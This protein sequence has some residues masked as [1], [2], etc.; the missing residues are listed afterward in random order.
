MV[1]VL[2]YVAL[3]VSPSIPRQTGKIKV[4][5]WTLDYVVE[6]RGAPCL[7][8]GS[9]IYYPRTFSKNL[10]RHLKLIF[11]DLPW[12]APA[13]GPIDLTKYTIDTVADEV[14][15]IRQKLKLDKPI[16]MGHSV[17]GSIALEYARRHPDHV[18]KLVMICSPVLMTSDRYEA[19]AVEIWKGASAERRRLQEENWRRLPDFTKHPELQADV[20]N[21]VAMGP[22][23]WRDPH[24]N[25]RWIWAGMTI[26]PEVLHHLFDDIFKNYDMFG[27][28]RTV[29]VPSFVATGRF[30]YVIP[31]TSWIQNR[32][33][34][35]LTVSLF[36]QS[37][38][39]PQL[40]E[41]M[42]FDKRLLDWWSLL[43]KT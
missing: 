7:V 9:S 35:N 28:S 34:P 22:K 29:P 32:D 19:S 43:L 42:L 20:E 18:A 3:G 12:F 21:Y 36:P 8:L 11:V 26:H 13:G 40:E 24:Y 33:I 5:G 27:N 2:A 1:T 17:H 15:A 16:V 10:R 41:P 23:Y 30:D 14:D 39:T 25:A 37:G 4:D 31:H 6:G 38:H